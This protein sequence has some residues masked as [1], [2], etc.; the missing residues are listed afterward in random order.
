[1]VPKKSAKG[2]AQSG[3]CQR[4]PRRPQSGEEGG[5]RRGIGASGTLRRQ[6]FQDPA[7]A[8]PGVAEPIVEPV[9]AA[10]P[11]LDRLRDE[12]I[13]APGI[14]PRHA[15]AGVAV[16]AHQLPDRLLELAAVRHHAALRRGD[17]A[18]TAAEGPGIE[19]GV[20]LLRA[21]AL[22]RA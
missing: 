20:G 14:R 4:T 5:E 9:R 17:G 18:E 8:P 1:M 3:I 10:L 7:F 15:L 22:D 13:A 6:A 16:A 12:A 2:T 21:G 11:E 19:V